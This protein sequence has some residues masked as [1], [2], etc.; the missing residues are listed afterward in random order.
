MNNF[1]TNSL[2]V[3]QIIPMV[4]RNG[5]KTFVVSTLHIRNVRIFMYNTYNK[6]SL[7]NSLAIN[8]VV[9]NINNNK[10]N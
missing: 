6:C 1:N 2:R 3:S 7:S 4:D 5:I 9:K 10:N 8:N